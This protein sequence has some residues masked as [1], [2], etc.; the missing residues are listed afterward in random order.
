[1][2]ENNIEELKDEALQKRVWTLFF[3]EEWDVNEIAQHLSMT[4]DHIRN[5]LTGEKED[6]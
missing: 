3:D 4:K 2:K 1:M 5:I 6:A